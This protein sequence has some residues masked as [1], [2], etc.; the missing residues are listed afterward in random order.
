MAKG[1]NVKTTAGGTERSGMEWYL[2]TDW[3]SHKSLNN[4]I[5]VNLVGFATY[6]NIASFN[7]SVEIF[8]LNGTPHVNLAWDNTGFY[9]MIH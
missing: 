4:N 8:L 9:F 3:N 2:S 6:Q 5:K 7:I 1:E